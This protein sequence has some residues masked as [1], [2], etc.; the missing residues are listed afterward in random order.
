MSADPVEITSWE[1]EVLRAVQDF[2]KSDAARQHMLLETQQ[3]WITNVNVME[4]LESPSLPTRTTLRELSAKGLLAEKVLHYSRHF[5]LTH[6]GIERLIAGPP[7]DEVD[8]FDSKTWTGVVDPIQA[9]RAL[10]IVSEMEDVCERMTNN[11]DRAQIMGLVRALELLLTIPEPPRLGIVSLVRDPAF[12]N[13][14][15]V[16]AFLA[17]LV[18]AVKS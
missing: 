16:A 8:A 5:R 2:S 9:E 7:T 17:A 1:F 14:I 6:K 15:Q 4:F 12:S 18:A 13:I 11:F 10:F 3:G